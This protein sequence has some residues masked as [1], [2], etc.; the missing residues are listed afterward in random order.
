MPVQ[1]PEERINNFK[2]VA[3]GYSVEDALKE[4]ERCLQCKNPS[5]VQ[6]CPVG[7]DIRDFIKLITERKFEEAA[8]KIKE[9]NNLPAVCGRVCPQ[10]EQCE[11]KCVLGIKQEPVAIGRLERFVADYVRDKEA[12]DEI[13][14]Q[15]KGKV[16][17]VGS[18]PAGLTAAADLAK[19]GYQVTIFEAFH[20]PGGVLTYGI[21]EFRLPKEIVKD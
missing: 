21:P 19:K 7:V 15:D 20:E 4:A 17:I 16:A 14:A 18:G 5:C 11:A 8:Q 1:E 12:I 3:L 10:E 2:E 6:G 9:K 13:P